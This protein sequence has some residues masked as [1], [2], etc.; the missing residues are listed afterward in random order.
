[1]DNIYTSEVYKKDPKTIKFDIEMTTFNRLQTPSE[2]KATKK[3]IND[4]GQLHPIVINDDTNLA[5]DGRHRVKACIELG[6]DVKCID[7]DHNIDRADRMSIYNVADMSGRVLTT[8]QRAIQAH[9]FAIAAKCTLA[10]AAEK[11]NT[12]DRA[13]KAANA[14]AG[15][16]RQDVFDEIMSSEKGAWIKP[17]G[18]TTTNL[19]LI[20]SIL[21]AEAQEVEVVPSVPAKVD[22]ESM[23]NTER[24]KIAFWKIDNEIELSAHLRRLFVIEHLNMKYKLVD[25][26]S[27]EEK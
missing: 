24:A 17:D 26:T 21:T 12:N 10:L 4:N 7:I 20:A 1:M 11:W 23:I 13:V 2:Y 8:S 27:K 16:G 3:S 22:Y 15:L 25:E 6:I 14:I 5:E 18:A 9:K 19:R